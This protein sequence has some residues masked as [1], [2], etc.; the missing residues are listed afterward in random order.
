MHA[1]EEMHHL[2]RHNKEALRSTMLI[3]EVCSDMHLS[4]GLPVLPEFPVPA[5][6]DVTTYF[7]HVAAEGHRLRGLVDSEN[8]ADGCRAG[9]FVVVRSVET[10]ETTYHTCSDF[11]ALLKTCGGATVLAIDIP[12][13]LPE[14]AERGGRPVDRLAREYLK[15]YRSSSV[16]SPPCRPTLA[17]GTYEEA[18][19]ITRACSSSGSSLTQ[20]A[21]G[22]LPKLREVDELMTPDVQRG[23]REVHPE[24]CF[25]LMNEDRPLKISKK[26]P[27]GQELRVRLLRGAGFDISAKTVKRLAKAG[28]GR[29]DVL[30]AFAAHEQLDVLASGSHNPFIELIDSDARSLNSGSVQPRQWIL[31]HLD[32]RVLELERLDQ[33]HQLRRLLRDQ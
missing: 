31:G 5:P 32:L 17:A 19:A 10:G 29:V 26:E 24:L 4:L 8:R 12:I 33:H 23:V 20:Q 1:G 25:A 30:D 14:Q 2:F 6:F 21:F 15:P 3:A 28:V 18:A 13:G 27:A 22:L 16:F 7:R 9:W 11:D